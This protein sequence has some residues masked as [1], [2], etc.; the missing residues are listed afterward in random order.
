MNNKERLLANLR[1]AAA[2]LEKTKTPIG[3][4]P[5]LPQRRSA[6]TPY[7]KPVNPFGRVL[8]HVAID[9]GAITWALMQY[10]QTTGYNL[11]TDQLKYA[12]NIMD[13]FALFQEHIIEFDICTSGPDFLKHFR[14]IYYRG[15][16]PVNKHSQLKE[17]KGVPHQFF[18]VVPAGMITIHDIPSYAGLI[19]A[20]LD[21]S[22]GIRLAIPKVGERLHDRSL[23][24]NAYK[25][26]S[27]HIHA[28][29]I[30]VLKKSMID[31]LPPLG[32]PTD[33]RPSH[34]E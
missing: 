4:K 34:T 30:Q 29:Y 11:V 23:A 22:G 21:A 20:H 15:T 19:T 26:I 8:K 27:G 7:S 12:G 31:E 10:L 18:F 1:E 14:K 6:D 2:D 28:R 17:G 3:S 24:E 25:T 16:Y 9:D 5:V 13:V 33:S 32:N